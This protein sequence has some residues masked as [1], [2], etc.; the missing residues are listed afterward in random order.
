M[1]ANA[2]EIYRKNTVT[3]ICTVTGLANLDDYV[4]T[5]TVKKYKDD[6]AVVLTKVGAIVALVITFSLG[7]SE[8]DETED[9]YHYDIVI[10]KP[11]AEEDSLIYTVTQ[12]TLRIKQSVLN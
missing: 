4:A 7:S 2:I 10:I 11:V 5:L 8:T 12:D 9:I 3:V 6:A 1:G